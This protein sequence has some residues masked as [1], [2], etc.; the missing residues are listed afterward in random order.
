MKWTRK[1]PTEPGWY[2]HRATRGDEYYRRPEVI[3]IRLYVNRLALGNSYI[4]REWPGGEWAGPIPLPAEK[5][6]KG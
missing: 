2:W 4:S 5:G 1:T 3:R 6:A